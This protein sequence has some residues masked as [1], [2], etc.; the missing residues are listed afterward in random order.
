VQSLVALEVERRLVTLE[1]ARQSY[2]VV[3]SPGKHENMRL[4]VNAPETTALRQELRDSRA[5]SVSTSVFNRGGTIQE[6]VDA[7]EAETG[8]PP[9]VLP[10]S[11]TL[12][13]PAAKAASSTC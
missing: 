7:C 9:P 4:V 12:R 5:A 10:S 8:L 2:G 13:G 11:R 1:G 3:L 6:L